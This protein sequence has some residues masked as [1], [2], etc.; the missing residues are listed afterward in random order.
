MWFCRHFCLA[1]G[2]C[3]LPV[4]WNLELVSGDMAS[5]SNVFTLVIVGLRVLTAIHRLCVSLLLSLISVVNQ[6]TCNVV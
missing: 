6:C 3:L 2:C 5:P 4:S 1:Q